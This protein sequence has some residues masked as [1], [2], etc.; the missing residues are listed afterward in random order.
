MKKWHLLLGIFVF[1]YSFSLCSKPKIYISFQWH[2]H[3]PIYWPYEPVTETASA[4]KYG[5]N[6]IQIFTD[7]AGAYT[8]FAVDAI[9]AGKNA[10]L[11]HLGAQI[12]FSGSLAENLN[13]LA[14]AGIAFK[15]WTSRWVEG[16][17]W[18][19]ALGNNRLEFVRFG[20]H[21]PLMALISEQSLIK[22][23]SL[24]AYAIGKWI[25]AD[26][27]KSK[28][29]F[30]PENGFSEEM[31]PG[32]V[33]A[34]IKWVFVDNI[35]FDRARKDYPYTKASNLP[36]P[37]LADQRDYPPVQWVQLNTIW[38]P[39]KVSVPWGYQPHYIAYRDPNTGELFKII[40]VPTARY[41]GNEDGKGGFGA[42][43]YEMVF[44]QYEAYN[45]DEKHPMLVV[46]HHDGD[47]YGGGMESYY[48]GNWMNFIAW[49]KNNPDRF[50]ATT[51]EDY[52]AKFP[53][54]E[55]DIIHVEP[56]SWSGADNGDPEFKKW[57]G[58][59]DQTGYSP[60]R[61][62]WA[63]IVA[64]TN[65][66]ETAQSKHPEPDLNDILVGTGNDMAKAWHFFLN[67]Q[68]SCYWYWDFSE[69]GKWDS[70]PTRAVN[71]AMPFIDTAL[72]KVVD[73]Y[74]PTIYP[75]QRDPYNP[76]GYEWSDKPMPSDFIVWTYV[77]D[78][79]GLEKVELKW[80]VEQGKNLTDQ[81]KDGNWNSAPMTKI[82]EPSLSDP[83]PM[84]KADRYEAMIKGMSNVMISYFVE[85][86]DKMGNI[87][88]S[89]IKHVW[90]G[91]PT[92][93]PSNNMWKPENP[94]K[95]EEIQIYSDKPGFLHWGVNGWKKPIE[96]YWPSG[97]TLWTDG[98][99][100]E[101]PLEEK[102]KVY[103]TKIGPFNNP[104][105]VVNQVNFVFHWKDG[106]WG[107]DNIINITEECGAQETVEEINQEKG[108]EIVVVN[109]E[110]AVEGLTS[111]VVT[112]VE[113]KEN[114]AEHP[115]GVDIQENLS[116]EFNENLDAIEEI[117]SKPY[118]GWSS[119]CSAGKNIGV[120]I[121]T[122][123]SI[124][125]LVR[126]CKRDLV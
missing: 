110:D 51:V 119:G 118:K 34:G 1:L 64:A 39:S 14:S 49:L 47:N 22:Q 53:P 33:K 62:S 123:F 36:P 46:L 4:G 98:I 112:A 21:H 87:G 32:L 11:P 12:S 37:N 106:T 102:D 52:L 86:K 35:H 44:S 126:R 88:R 6:L 59:P 84:Y 96:E 31:I 19:T 55:N 23:I 45:T 114:I 101:S 15:G 20:Y 38:A 117:S 61:H 48:H 5:F 17:K 24:H 116:K 18:K 30:P 63:V 40:A 8:T 120:I 10:G 75:L 7:R 57:N 95:D 67:A 28:G 43:Q 16:S 92:G 82:T 104:K 68:T 13:T 105:Q 100:V 73:Q 97:T 107:K 76:G 115:I 71:L 65:R 9:E 111:E 93:F 80:K 109:D 124:P 26:L 41:E 103:M 85:S 122:L 2:Y 83:K 90:V 56:G 78:V 91:L 54:D 108:E 69:G 66:I 81:Y 99:A 27:A 3:Q 25:S 29:L 58:D 113:D 77:Y 50:E 70:H 125:M 94:C 79:S 42:L 89:Q 74:P 72:S 121:I 60:D